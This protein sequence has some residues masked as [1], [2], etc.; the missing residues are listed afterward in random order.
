M[1][2]IRFLQFWSGSLFGIIEKL[3]RYCYNRPCIQNLTMVLGIVSLNFIYSF[4]DPLLV[5]LV[6]PVENVSERKSTSLNVFWENKENNYVITPDS[7]LFD[8]SQSKCVVLAKSYL[9]EIGDKHYKKCFV[10][11]AFL[12]LLRDGKKPSCG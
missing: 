7:W 9:C 6:N 3:F 10:E 5:G 11:L 4:I 12:C 8:F 2:H 1:K